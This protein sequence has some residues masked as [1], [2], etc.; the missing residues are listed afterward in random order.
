LRGNVG[1]RLRK[2]AEGSVDA[3][4]LACAGLDRLGYGELI[5][6]RLSIDHMLPA[7]GQ[8]ALA[9]ERRA[10]DERVRALCLALSDPAAEIAVAAERALLLGLGAGCRTPVGGFAEICPQDGSEARLTVHGLIGYPDGHA[11]LRERL[12]GPVSQAAALGAALAE[13]LLKR[14]GDAILATFF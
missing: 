14:G 9:V 4:I 2:V 5:T 13:R 6:E 8:G 3:A 7:I 10:N 12:E 1:T 11:V